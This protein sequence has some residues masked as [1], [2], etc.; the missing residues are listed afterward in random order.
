MPFY[1]FVDLLILSPPGRGFI[2]ILD[3]VGENGADLGRIDGDVNAGCCAPLT[4]CGWQSHVE[5]WPAFSSYPSQQTMKPK[6]VA[7]KAII[8]WSLIKLKSTPNHLGKYRAL[9]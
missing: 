2:T 5:T 1:S 9:P 8:D 6:H 3:W 4:I 7:R